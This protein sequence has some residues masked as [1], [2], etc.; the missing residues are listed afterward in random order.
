MLI[1][2]RESHFP[3]EPVQLPSSLPLPSTCSVSCS[4]L[5]CRRHSALLSPLPPHT[6]SLPTL[7][8][9]LPSSSCYVIAPHLCH[10]P[11]ALSSSSAPCCVI[12]PLLCH[13]MI[14]HRPLLRHLSSPPA[15][16]PVIAPGCVTC[17]RPLLCHLSSPP[18][19]SLIH[20]SEPTRQS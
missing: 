2:L 7:L 13:L 6:P 17:H 14:C 3:S 16:P 12:V 8:C 11:P 20:I 4:I 9:H 15:T 18:Y 1:E 19:L 5:F 10:R